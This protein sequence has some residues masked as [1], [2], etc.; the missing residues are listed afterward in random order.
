MNLK[1]QRATEQRVKFDKDCIDIPSEVLQARDD[2]KLAFFCGAGISIDTGLP[3]FNCLFEKV[4]IEMRVGKEDKK[5]YNKIIDIERKFTALEKDYPRMRKEVIEILSIAVEDPN[6]LNTHKAILQL[7]QHEDHMHLVTTNFD[8]RFDQAARDR[9]YNWGI[10]IAPKL[11][12]PHPDRWNSL[13]YLHGKI[14]D[15]DKEGSGLVLTTGD[16]G[17][18][19]L[20]ERQASRFI[21]ELVRNFNILLI[22]YSA[23]DTMIRYLFEAFAAEEDENKSKDKGFYKQIWAFAAYKKETEREVR[24]KW[25]AMG[26]DPILYDEDYGKRH[27]PKPKPKHKLLH[28]TLRKWH[29]HIEHSFN[30]RVNKLIDS[31]QS[32]PDNEN[33]ER[34]LW[35]IQEPGTYKNIE[36]LTYDLDHEHI[37]IKW[38][39][40]LKP[41]FLQNDLRHLLSKLRLGTSHKTLR[42]LLDILRPKLPKQ[43]RDILTLKLPKDTL[44]HWISNNL[45]LPKLLMWLIDNYDFL[46]ENLRT[47]ID[48]KINRSMQTTQGNN[49]LDKTSLI[50][51]Q[52]L[53]LSSSTNTDL[54]LI[55]D[56]VV[57]SVQSLQKA[58]AGI[59]TQQAVFRR[60]LDSIDPVITPSKSPSF[61]YRQARQRRAKDVITPSKSL[62]F[63]YTLQFTVEYKKNSDAPIQSEMEKLRHL[64]AYP[65]NLEIINASLLKALQLSEY[66]RRAPSKDKQDHSTSIRRSV[67]DHDQ[68]DFSTASYATHIWLVRDVIG[69]VLKKDKKR[70]YTILDNWLLQPYP[71]FQRLYLHIC[72]E[73]KTIAQDKLDHIADWLCSEDNLWQFGIKSELCRFLRKA[74]HRLSTTKLDAICIK[75]LQGPSQRLRKQWQSA[76]KENQRMFGEDVSDDVIKKR[77]SIKVKLEKRLRLA[78]LKQNDDL[79]LS[80][81]LLLSKCTKKWKELQEEAKKEGYEESGKHL[82]FQKSVEKRLKDLLEA[83]EEERLNLL[84]N[85]LKYFAMLD[86]KMMPEK[87]EKQGEGMRRL[88][89]LFWD[90]HFDKLDAALRVLLDYEDEVADEHY[91]W[92]AV[93]DKCIDTLRNRESTKYQENN[94]KNADSGTA[95]EHLRKIVHLSLTMLDRL[96]DNVLTKLE[97]LPARMLREVVVLLSQDIPDKTNIQRTYLSVWKKIWRI[98]ENK[99]ANTRGEYGVSCRNYGS[100]K[101]EIDFYGTAIKHPAG[102][103]TECLIAALDLDNERLKADGGIPAMLLP[104]FDMVFKADKKF[105]LWAYVVF[106]YWLRFLNKTDAK[107]CKE[108]LLP[109]F[110]P[111]VEESIAIWSGYVASK[112]IGTELKEDLLNDLIR[113][114]TK[115]DLFS[116]LISLLE[117]NKKRFLELKKDKELIQI[118]KRFMFHVSF[119]CDRYSL[120]GKQKEKVHQVIDTFPNELLAELLPYFYRWREISFDE[121]EAY[122]EKRVEPF[123]DV[124]WPKNR[125]KQSPESNQ[126]FYKIL[127]LTGDAFPKAFDYLREPKLIQPFS[128]A[129]EAN[130]SI[131]ASDVVPGP[132]DP[133]LAHPDPSN[134]ARICKKYP[135]ESLVML[136][137]AYKNILKPDN[138]WAFSDLRNLLKIIEETNKLSASEKKNLEALRQKFYPDQY[139]IV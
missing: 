104:Y 44:Q 138:S 73:D 93:A 85:S 43:G 8:D 125:N 77:L 69:E 105:S 63:E 53:I 137:T 80:K 42:D 10:D 67:K 81:S 68:N 45:H 29:N 54:H 19:Y 119:L 28:N 50:N 26:I 20:T 127:S 86:I 131:S 17:R 100:G 111:N 48:E 5:K 61:E 88:I 15:E 110:N 102:I 118:K 64:Y 87:Q 136:R 33:T 134:L 51:W 1:V 79:A 41:E 123:I 116:N 66:I 11:S 75:I 38:L 60:F 98:T 82:D 126:H 55:V 39:D 133:F 120:K 56:E 58:K 83:P 4:C 109:Y 49:N 132:V 89:S 139:P 52:K 18:I 101:T 31:L 91:L 35:A 47:R 124:Y 74:A 128:S 129:N 108:H 24:N 23:E 92:L 70:A 7:A 9:E 78:G 6:S 115:K 97:D 32:E 59:I 3:G 37:F 57:D 103:L 113:L 65:G 21:T 13:V 107:W 27:E 2:G 117:P 90:K 114:L 30:D 99:Q 40:K 34:V 16:Y 14:T 94:P 76:Y 72:I 121:G 130:E 122:W 12:V 96:S 71:V 95:D 25:D 84:R 36:K 46:D 62:S 22:G 135:K 106:A 112:N